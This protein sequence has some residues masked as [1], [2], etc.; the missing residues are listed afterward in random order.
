MPYT[1]EPTE[2]NLEEEREIEMKIAI[3]GGTGFVGRHLARAL[4][5]EGHQVHLISR[6]LDQRDREIYQLSG[7]TLFKTSVDD[8][9]GLE[10]ALAGCDAVAHCAGI[11]REIGK[12]TYQAVHI[13]GTRNVVEAAKNQ[14][15][16]KVL[17]LSFLRARPDCGS[18]YHE[19]KWKA[20]ETVRASGLDYTILKA[21][22]IYGKGDHMLDHLSHAFHTFPLFGLVGLKEKP[23]RP[24]AID[25]MV[26]VLKAAI[27]ENRLTNKTVAVLGPEELTLEEAVKRVALVVGKRPFFFRM[28]IVAHQ[29]FARLCE[30]FMKTP[31]VARAQIQ[32][33]SESVVEPGPLAEP[34]PADLQPNIPFTEEQIRQ[35]LPAAKRLGVADLRCPT[36]RLCQS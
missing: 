30:L 17:F 14:G 24:T 7:S 31:L 15:V 13:Q 12:Q 34:L 2:K 9:A 29:A 22:V 10:G 18:A 28:P 1:N 36:G 8:L 35:G 3:T 6:G 27:L 21:G 5:D 25:D 32:I 33:L 20:E 16:K 23:V 4:T 19:S 26:R 11:N